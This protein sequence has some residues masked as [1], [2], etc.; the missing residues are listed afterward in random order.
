MTVFKLD[1]DQATDAVKV[2]VF[3]SK[4]E[5][6]QSGNGGTVI[7]SAEELLSKVHLTGPLLVGIYNSAAETPVNKFSDRETACRRVWEVLIAKLAPEPVQKPASAKPEK[8]APKAKEKAEK[9][10]K[11]PAKTP[12][13]KGSRRTA[14][15]EL[16]EA[17]PNRYRIGTISHK[18]YE[19]VAANPTK[20][21]LEVVALGAKAG[22]ISEML[23]EGTAIIKKTT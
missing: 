2:T 5:A 11:S 14:L 23:R 20:S 10:S 22:V 15:L 9:R 7:G 19:L 17:K 8:E 21:F 18:S 6:G 12:K 16:V 3:H 1:I 13:L 4:K